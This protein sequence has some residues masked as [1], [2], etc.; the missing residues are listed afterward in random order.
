MNAIGFKKSFLTV[1]IS[2]V[3]IL[4]M[5]FVYRAYSAFNHKAISGYALEGSHEK[6]KC[7]TCHKDVKDYKGAPKDCFSCHKEK[8]HKDKVFDTNCESCHN[9]VKWGDA[10]MD[11]KKHT[12]PVAH[13]GA[14]GCKDCHPKTVKEYSCYECHE[15][16]PAKMERKHIK[17]GI[18]NYE[19]CMECHPTGLEHEGEGRGWKGEGKGW[20]FWERDKG[21]DRRYKRDNYKRGKEWDDN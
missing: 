3:I 19:N 15:H 4:G 5:S 21:D 14:K 16:N 17:E 6:A 1:C 2:L 20:K 10:K 9:P 7:N 8:A 13:R 11:I 18:R 12:F